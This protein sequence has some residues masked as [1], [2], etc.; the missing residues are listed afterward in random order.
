MIDNVF[1]SNYFQTVGYTT[2]VVS[3]KL[4]EPVMKQIDFCKLSEFSRS[5]FRW[6]LRVEKN[7]LL[8]KVKVKLQSQFNLTR[9]KKS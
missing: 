4:S 9:L 8:A 2:E 6:K 7:C 3:T 1:Y 5:V